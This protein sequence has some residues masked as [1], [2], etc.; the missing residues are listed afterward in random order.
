LNALEA[1][2]A[3]KV[4][5]V[6]VD[7]PFNTGAAFPHYD[8]GLEHSIWMDLMSRRFGIMYNLLSE[9]GVLLVHLDDNEAAYCKVILDEIFGRDNYR[10]TITVK[11]NSPFGFKH[12]SS[13]IFKSANYILV[14]S[15]SSI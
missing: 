4:K 11:A 10:N 15:K 7:P 12:T 6:Y 1:E 14:Y 3:G 2:Y 13:N 8:D 5:C 9:D